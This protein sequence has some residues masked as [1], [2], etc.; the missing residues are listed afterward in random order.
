M[1]QPITRREVYAPSM[2]ATIGGR[3][4]EAESVAMDRVLPD[5]LTGGTLTAASGTISAVEGADTVEHV[6]TPW[7]PGTAWPPVPES[8]VSVSVD[9]GAGPVAILSDGRVAG[10]AGGTSGR[11]VSVDVADAYET[12]NRTISWD[13]LA[14][15]MPGTDETVGKQNYVSLMTE[16]ITDTIF[17]HCGWYCTP[18]R[19]PY[20]LL[21]VPAMGT[22]FPERGTL[23]HSTG[24]SPDGSYPLFARAPWG[25]AVANGV[26]ARYS[27][28]ATYTLKDRGNL[29]MTAMTAHSNVDGSIR[30][31]AV[32][33]GG[34][35]RLS[36]SNSTAYVW[37]PDGS[38]TLRSAVTV[39]RA[40]GFLYASVS[41]V[42]DTSVAVTL[43]SGANVQS[44][45][46]AVPAALTMTGVT[47]VDITGTGVGAGFQVAYP[48]VALSL[49]SWVP[50][51]VIHSRE[52]FD[53]N[54]LVVR[55]AVSGADCADL[56][57]AKAEAEC[58]TFWID[59]L[60][61]LHWWDMSTLEGRGSVASL[62]SD[63]DIADD[64]FTWS[65]DMSQVKSRV[66]V[67]WVDPVGKL[68]GRPV[69]DVWQGNGAMLQSGSLTTEGW[70]NT[71][72]DEVWIG[73]DTSVRRAGDSDDDQL[74]NYGVGSWF[75]GVV[76]D[77]DAWAQ[78]LGNISM[79][80]ERVTDASYKYR[81][82]WAPAHSA[83][84]VTLRTPSRGAESGLWG[85]R[86]E[87]DLP[88]LRASARYELSE[89]ITYSTQ[90]GP[91]RAPEHVIDAGWWIQKPEQAAW[92][93][94]YAATRVTV[95][96]PVLSS[97][98][99]IPVPGLQ[100]GDVVTV[101]DRHVTRLTVR[102]LVVADSRSL[103]ADMGMSHAVA[104]RPTSVTRDGVTWEEWGAVMAGRSWET[105]GQQQLSK[106]WSQWGS[107]PLAGEEN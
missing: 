85:R 69:A 73:V 63:D 57:R 51:A 39:P 106:T 37:L 60:G 20:V 12:L 74:F 52:T 30:L 31:D 81:V 105:W 104:I 26:T 91:E 4:V 50:N 82:T 22:M 79:S 95:P 18:P 5:P 48:T 41:Y 103:D 90:T 66:A 43:R 101:Q 15:R 67:K 88:I 92:V 40:D 2:T 33:A 65:H 89:Q 68:E 24:A 34:T 27:F 35:A 87:M 78:Q 72:S 62:T 80:L 76:D 44:A 102:G 84:V 55:P 29:E 49:A 14:D 97:V 8:P 59:E 58:A 94:A 32:S 53:G 25:R 19:L 16:S 45:T 6:S 10:V 71:P 42:S 1:Q 99:L 96:Q 11:A 36:W 93:A 17:R 75:G 47:R 54:S 7:D 107:D 28:P 3:A 9:T 77:S 13:A 38:G 23:E 64:G 86:R 83:Y 100:I 46:V 61:I 70:I 98:A 21:S 56:L